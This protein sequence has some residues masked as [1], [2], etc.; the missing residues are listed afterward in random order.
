GP[1]P[2]A[3]SDVVRDLAQVECGWRGKQGSTRHADRPNESTGREHR[4]SSAR[5]SR[6]EPLEIPLVPG[7]EVVLRRT[8]DELFHDKD[9][10]VG[11]RVSCVG[12]SPRDRGNELVPHLPQRRELSRL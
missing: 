4:V 12:Q 9:R 5:E 10:A 1:W 2:P 8:G 7:V 3:L 6:D 11:A